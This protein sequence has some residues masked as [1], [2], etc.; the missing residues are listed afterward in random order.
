MTGPDSIVARLADVIAS[1]KRER[2]GGSYTVELLDAGHAALSAKVIEE[3]YELIAA[4]GD[5]QTPDRAAVT[6]EA[7]DVVY[8]LL[9]FLA[10]CDCNWSDVERELEQRFGTGGLQAKAARAKDSA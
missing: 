1:R 9:V 10:A 5:D 6:H 2:P 8:H 3:A 7:A 4:V